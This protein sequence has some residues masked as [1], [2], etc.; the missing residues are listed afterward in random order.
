MKATRRNQHGP[1][2]VTGQLLQA[3]R[4]LLRATTAEEV[5]S[6]LVVTLQ[7]ALGCRDVAWYVLVADATL[8]LS[9][10][11][12]LLTPGLFPAQVGLTPA[13]GRGQA[14]LA[15]VQDVPPLVP[16]TTQ[17][18]GL[19]EL[20]WL[21]G[22][23]ALHGAMVIAAE[24]VSSRGSAWAQQVG[25]LAADAAVA[26]DRLLPA[27]PTTMTPTMHGAISALTDV[28]LLYGGVLD[29]L[30]GAL[31]GQILD[32]LQVA[33]GAIYLATAEPDQLTLAVSARGPNPSVV[34]HVHELWQPPAAEQ[35]LLQA[36]EVARQRSTVLITR[37]A[38][39]RTPEATILALELT[40]Q[41][42]SSLVGVPMLAGGW[43]TGVLQVVTHGPL[44]SEAQ[45]QLLRILAHLSAVAIENVRVIN[46][47]RADQ[48][49]TRAVVDASNDAILMLDERRRPMIVNRRARFFFGLT[50]HDL[51]G[52]SFDQLGVV[53][54]RIFEDGSRFSSWL[55]QLLHTQNERAVEEFGVLNPE[56]RL[57][58]CYSAPVIGPH[59][60]YLGRILVF[61]DITRER[62]VERMKNDFVSMV[63]HE[64]RTPLTSI[65][66]A[67]QLVIGRPGAQSRFGIELPAQARD[68]LGISLANTERLIRL[69]N[70]ILDIAKI[71]QG[72]IQ[73][74][75][76]ALAPDEICRSAL[77]AMQTFADDH[78]ISLELR[79][80]ARL[81]LVFVDRDRT[82]QILI[83]LLSN[84]I[85]FSTA[86]QRVLL[87]VAHD[88]AM[89]R[90]AVQDWGRGIPL[91]DQDRLFEKFQQIDSSSTRD[92]GGSGLGL[93]ISRAL[94][95]EHG[96]RMWIESELGRGSIFKF[97]LPLA[98]GAEPGEAVTPRLRAL[99]AELDPT[100][101]LGLA[102]A[103][104]AQ[105]WEVQ[106]VA[107]LAML[108]QLAG[109][110]EFSL[111]V[112]GWP[113]G[114]EGAPLLPAIQ[115][116]PGTVEVQILVLTDQPPAALPRR[117]VTMPRNATPAEVVARA[118]QLQAAWHPHV[119]V[120]DD[121]PHVRPVLA[122]LL[123][124]NGMRVTQVA[125]GYAAL[126]TVERNRPDVILLDIKMPG[127][128]GF[129]VLR[130][131][132]ANPATA[133]LAVIILTANDLSEPARAQG[134]ALG[135]RAFLEKPVAYERLISAV[136]D[137]IATDAAL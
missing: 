61:R 43:L 98:P 124:R 129:E 64:L 48:E 2:A 1:A 20:V 100:R 37:A 4:Q 81:P 60:H 72:R 33:G 121:D 84:A 137:V 90:I 54:Q 55:E 116:L 40:H 77:A 34:T 136:N 110:G 82:L 65:Q 70:D 75:R 97:T 32:N 113:L 80:P 26:L 17:A 31:L 126:A 27:L 73:L 111:V 25:A 117:A 58:Q 3:T 45:V 99:V 68:L 6:L 87:S 8:A 132:K 127:L 50:E 78:E 24:P 18:E 122:R 89:L 91:E 128:D 79:L 49:R 21:R 5:R 107:T 86:G 105:G 19:L 39:L 44:L 22:A 30:L 130:R 108:Q 131:L 15:E 38:P 125:D 67:L 28:G 29:R 56:P 16:L 10:D 135:A 134:H 104:S 85:K 57:L 95:E 118:L 83:N 71:E 69:I 52:K 11:Q 35:T 13:L 94:V 120:V 93:A 51:L 53:F 112:L 62:E 109:Q 36:R 42:L 76:E 102:T 14:A 115:A 23:T 106:T 63:S 92:A 12:P 133:A 66:G 74:R 101:R 41:G 59:E 96:G 119:L 46:Q 7:E 47:A 123:Q 114:D 9:P 103:L 88:G